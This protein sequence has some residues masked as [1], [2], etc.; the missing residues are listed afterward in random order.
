MVSLAKILRDFV[1]FMHNQMYL[2]SNCISWIVFHH[3]I[4]GKGNHS[5]LLKT[6]ISIAHFKSNS[7]IA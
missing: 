2:L 7:S 6:K 3:P 5:E 1:H 4:G